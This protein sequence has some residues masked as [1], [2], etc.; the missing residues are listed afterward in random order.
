MTRQGVSTVPVL[1]AIDR[2]S[3]GATL[4]RQIYDALRA[5]HRASRSDEHGLVMG[6]VPFKTAEIR[7]ALAQ[8]AD[9]IRSVPH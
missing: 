2:D 3:D 9:A 7:H 4:H 5:A 1:L 6:Y 8:L